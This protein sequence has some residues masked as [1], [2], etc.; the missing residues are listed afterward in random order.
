MMRLGGCKPE[1]QGTRDAVARG[2][3]RATLLIMDSR[4]SMKLRT[5]VRQ[6]GPRT[7]LEQVTSSSR[8]ALFVHTTERKE[9]LSADPGDAVYDL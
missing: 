9:E 4:R 7:L 8:F 3:A 6:S 5:Q 2:H 1:S